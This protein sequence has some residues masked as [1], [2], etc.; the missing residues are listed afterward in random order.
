MTNNNKTT[1]NKSNK[2]TKGLLAIA[3]EYVNAKYIDKKVQK[4]PTFFVTDKAKIDKLIEMFVEGTITNEELK[5][6]YLQNLHG[7]NDNLR[8]IIK[9]DKRP[10]SIS[11]K[12]AEQWGK[13]VTGRVDGDPKKDPDVGKVEVE[14]RLGVKLSESKQKQGE[15]EKIETTIGNIIAYMHEFAHSVAERNR[16]EKP[17]SRKDQQVED[18]GLEIESMFMENL[19]FKYVQEHSSEVASV[20]FGDK[21][22]IKDGGGIKANID[23]Y[24]G[25]KS[26]A[27]VVEDALDYYIEQRDRGFAEKL[28][29]IKNTPEQGPDRHQ[30][31]NR[32]KNELRYVVG[33][34]YS[35][36]L[37]EE[38]AKDPTMTID[39]FEEF[40]KHNSSLPLNDS[41]KVLFGDDKMTKYDAIKK[42]KELMQAKTLEMQAENDM[43][44]Q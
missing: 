39:R 29:Y 43:Q 5:Q 13:S 17:M 23:I 16:T 1:Q 25:K 22:V 33:E 8:T 27:K 41:T 21:P 37:N 36:A 18:F 38:L 26:G 6:R 28:D 11:G 4:K 12:D 35:F 19:F 31:K 10:R 24:L 2:K 3:N 44:M 7:E 32:K 42:F 34:M 30:I 15:P 40:L 20:L 9:T 14:A